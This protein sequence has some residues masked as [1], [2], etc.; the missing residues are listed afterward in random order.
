VSEGFARVSKQGVPKRAEPLV[1]GLRAL[2][3]QAKAA[4]VGLWRY[5]DVEEDEAHEFGYRPAAPAP[6]AKAANPWKK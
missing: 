3:E 4:H 6:A 1:A 2:E 5:G